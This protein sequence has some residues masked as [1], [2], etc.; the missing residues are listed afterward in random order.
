MMMSKSNIIYIGGRFFQQFSLK[1]KEILA[2]GL[3]HLYRRQ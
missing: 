1:I 2:H 3:V